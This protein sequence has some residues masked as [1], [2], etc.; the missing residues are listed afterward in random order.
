MPYNFVANSFHT[1]VTA[2]ALRAR[3]DRKS[4]ISLQRGHFGPKFQ[5]QGVAPHQSFLH[6]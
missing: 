3:I 5:V 4:A 2:E 1:G 6:G